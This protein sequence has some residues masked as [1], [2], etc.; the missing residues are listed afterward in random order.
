MSVVSQARSVDQLVTSTA[1]RQASPLYQH[2][3]PPSYPR[4][5]R[6]R[7]WQGT[8][9][10]Q[11]EVLA[12][13]NPGLVKVVRTSGYIMLDEAS[14]Q[15]VRAWRFQPATRDNKAISSWVEIPIRFELVNG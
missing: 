15:T 6:E 9:W 1:V 4:Q 10:L 3:P 5:A 14:V 7:G 8:T 13:G 11:V 12:D 2:N